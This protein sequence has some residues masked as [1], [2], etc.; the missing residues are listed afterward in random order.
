MASFDSLLENEFDTARAS[1]S[2][3]K[4]CSF[5]GGCSITVPVQGLAAN[6]NGGLQ[7]VTACGSEAVLDKERSD[8]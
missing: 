4:E 5:V 2:Y 7:K 1:S 6:V 8:A 3:T